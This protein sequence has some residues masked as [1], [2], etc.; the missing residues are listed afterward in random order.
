MQ[1]SID[2]FDPTKTSYDELNS[3]TE[4][5]SGVAAELEEAE[6]KWLTLAERADL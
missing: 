3:W 2:T 4:Q 1:R 6:L 5:L